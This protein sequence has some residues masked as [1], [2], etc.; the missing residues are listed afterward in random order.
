MH[1]VLADQAWPPYRLWEPRGGFGFPML[2]E[3]QSSQLYPL[4][5][6]ARWLLD[7]GV[8]AP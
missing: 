5:V 3:S 2:A 7:E 1:S 4:S 8:E 6:A